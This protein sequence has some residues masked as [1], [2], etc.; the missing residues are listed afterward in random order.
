MCAASTKGQIF[1]HYSNTIYLGLLLLGVV[2]RACNRATTE[3]V[4]SKGLRSG[5][6]SFAGLCRSGVHTKLGVNMVN[7]GEPSSTRLHKEERIGSGWKHSRQKFPRQTV[8]GW[9]L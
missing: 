6:L 5:L 3:L 7:C 4:V 9:H 2:A 1:H 8:V